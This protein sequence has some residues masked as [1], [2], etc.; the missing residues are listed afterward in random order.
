M[1]VDYSSYNIITYINEN[2]K[3]KKKEKKRKRKN[4]G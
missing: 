1:V 2:E 4:I 3:E